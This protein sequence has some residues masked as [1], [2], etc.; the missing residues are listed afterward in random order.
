LSPLALLL[1]ALGLVLLVAGAELLVRG[2]SRL[3]TSLGVTPLIIGLTVVAWGTSAPELAVNIQS[4]VQGVPRVA[5]G[6]VIGSNIFNILVILGLSALVAPL[7]VARQLV[8][9]DMPF[10]IAASILLLLLSLDGEISLVDGLILL[11]GMAVYTGWS[12]RRTHR[13]ERTSHED[14]SPT[15]HSR[16]SG[17][18]LANSFFMLAGLGLLVVGSRWLVDGSAAIADELGI[19]RLIV[20]LTIVAAGTSL[21]EAATSVVASLRGERDIA[22]GNV[23]GSNIANILGVLGVTA[24]IS[25]AGIPVPPMALHLDIPVMVAVAIACLPIS[26]TGYRVSRWEGAFLLMVYV[27]FVAYVVLD[28]LQHEAM[29]AFLTI[30]RTFVVPL[31][32]VT[33]LVPCVQ[34]FRQHTK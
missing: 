19:S 30:M 23:V 31:T 27:A 15:G 24:A 34:E 4:A 11:A 17:R 33:L 9:R 21:P 16:R 32:V 3:A 20:G 1:F 5:L 7:V 28:A 25:P 22:V 26:L 10:M 13:A 6:N 14:V 29:P 12:I 8:R 18:P 2:A